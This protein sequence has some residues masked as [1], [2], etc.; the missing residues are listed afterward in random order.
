MDS[1]AAKTKEVEGEATDQDYLALVL[2]KLGH[3][4]DKDYE[5][6]HEQVYRYI[7]IYIYI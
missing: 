5:F 6:T 7:Y 4:K 3:Q 1:G 2:E